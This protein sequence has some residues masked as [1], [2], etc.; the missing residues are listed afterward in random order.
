M[1]T[2]VMSLLVLVGLAVASAVPASANAAS[3]LIAKSTAQ[4]ETQVD[5]V[6][7]RRH[8]RRHGGLFL[9]FGGYPSYGYGYGYPRYRYYD[10]YSYYQP[11]YRYRSHRHHRHHHRRHSW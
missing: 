3:G 4:T 9:S 7:Y 8:H 5:Q 10:D 1:R 6:T 2:F 11:R